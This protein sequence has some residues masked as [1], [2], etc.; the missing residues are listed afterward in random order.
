[1][2][3]RRASARR[4]AIEW[5]FRGLLAIFAAALGYISVTYTLGYALK[6]RPAR[7]HV[8]APQD[9][10]IT[11]RMAEALMTPTATAAERARS[12]LLARLA[13]REDPTAS[14]AAA[15]LGLGAQIRGDLA[16]ARKLFAYAEALSRRDLQTQLWAIEDAVSRNDIPGALRHYDIALRTSRAAPDLL[17]PVLAS[18]AEDPAIRAVMT[19][20]LAGRP[21]WSADFLDYAARQGAD[22]RSIAQ[23]F[24]ASRRQGAGISD[25]TNAVLINRL[26]DRGFSD[27]AWTYYASLHPGVDRRVSRDPDFT[28]ASAPSVFDWRPINDGG[29]STS[30]QRGGDGGIVDFSAPPSVG[31]HVLQQVQVLPP[32]AYR[33][34]GRSTGIDQP[35]RSRPYWVLICPD[36]RELGRIDLPNSERSNG[37]FAGQFIVPTGCPIQKLALV[38]RPSDSVSGVAGQI[39]KAKLYPVR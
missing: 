5:G 36:G 16:A 19:K 23:L 29:I 26:I 6:E 11:A 38:V 21:S 14:R 4:P 17:F 13:L 32:G 37:A 18:A 39:S 8:L 3:R 10:R 9:G 2:P 33:L 12:E 24:W 15:V 34:E 20:T 7:A 30:I 1:M 31:G 22:P 28:T 25:E 27:A 35:D